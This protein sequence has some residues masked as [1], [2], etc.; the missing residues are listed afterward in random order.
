MDLNILLTRRKDRL[1]VFWLTLSALI[2]LIDYHIGPVIQFPILFTVPVL[3]ASWYSGARWG[4]PLAVALPL[5]RLYFNA[6]RPIPW[7]L[8]DSSVNALIRMSILS[9]IS[10]LAAAAS[11]EKHRLEETV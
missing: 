6:T 10:L 8:L 9:T 11:R 3:L 2:V 5:I 4:V 7:T 1:P